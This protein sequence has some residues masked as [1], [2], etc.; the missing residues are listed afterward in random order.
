ML[1]AA[2]FSAY[3][4]YAQ[5]TGN[6]VEIFGKDKVETVEEG[7]IIH[8]FTQGL[9]LRNAMKPGM[10]TGT[11]DIVF[12]QIAT[13]Q[14]DRPQAGSK[15]N[16]RYENDPEDQVLM[17]EAIEA[18]TA[19]IFQGDLNRAYVYTE[20]ESPEETIALL[21]ATGHTRVFINGLPREGDHYDYGYTLI[22]FK[23]QKGLNQFV[24]TYGRF[25]RVGS[26]IILPEKPVQ[27][28]SRDITLPS[29]IRGENQERWGAVRVINATE[30][31]VSGYQIFCILETG[32]QTVQEMDHIISLTTRKVKFRIPF[33]VRTI[34]ADSMMATLILKNNEGQEIDRMK[35][36]LTV[37]NANR[38]HE[39]TFISQIDGSVQYYS[40]APSTSDE[41]GQAFVLSVHGASV[42]ATN[43][44]RAYKQKDWA[45]IVA[46]TNRRPFGFNWEEWGRL[47]ALEVLHEARKVFHTDS[48]RTYLTGHSMGGHGTWFLGATYPDK[49]AAIA[50]A[51]GYPDIISYRRTGVDSAMFE[52]PH[53]EMIYR[54]ARTGRVVDL[55]RNYL[56][57][58]VYVLHGGADAVVPVEQA[59]M[60][61][62]VLGKFHNNFT[63]YEYPGGS[64]WYGDHCMDWPPLFDFLRQNSIPVLKEVDSI[65]F[66]TASPGVS[67][68]NYWLCINQQIHPNEIS[69][70]KAV[71]SGDTIGFETNNVASITFL[72]S[73]LDFEN[74]PVLSVQD[75]FIHAETDKDVTLHFRQGHW[76]IVDAVNLT[77][78]HPGR[79]GGFKLAFTNNMVFVYATNGN[80]EENEWY[81]NKAH[82]DAETFWYRGN[83]SIDI[84]PDTDFAPDHYA[85]RNVIIYGN[86]DNNL[87]WNQLLAHCPVQV[88]NGSISFGERVFDCESL[89]T[90]FIYPRP[91]SQFASVG[92]VAASGIDGMKALYP[93]DYFSG[94]TGFPDLMIFD[95]DL[96]KESL[97]SVIVSGFFGNDWSVEGGEFVD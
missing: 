59:R 51:A 35:I 41:P 29:I 92:V 18:D 46:P 3:T 79:Y 34:A 80:T 87:A 93:N 30:E 49:W 2:L 11:Q 15:L 37:M 62:E 48:A 50:P 6:I 22:P 42:E 10:L 52:A 70:V 77:E 89:G 71:K 96:I 81:K 68:S 76:Q 20:F 9:A 21:D 23:L 31:T 82:F 32:E 69:Q 19:G 27:F 56:Q 94:I 90:Y 65:E 91:D 61:R 39:R 24:Y 16:H 75:K 85:D 95:V 5:Q 64:H 74:K 44:T 66:Q 73:Q 88:K 97:G 72:L 58:G 54:G 86:A 43:Q 36:K 4:S 47:D 67:A 17:W 55:A 7:I 57:S 1:L 78:K 14:F 60:M 12:W 26:K 28:T 63:Y 53:F 40:I 8:E 45:H 13:K 25:G 38:H 83:G 84:I 33:P